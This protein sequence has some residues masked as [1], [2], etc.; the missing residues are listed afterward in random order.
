MHACI[1]IWSDLHNPPQTVT[2]STSKHPHPLD[3]LTIIVPI[4]IVP[5]PII[6]LDP[7]MLQANVNK[8]H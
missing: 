6:I 5:I 3:D 1:L 8:L 2:N 4:V 7:D